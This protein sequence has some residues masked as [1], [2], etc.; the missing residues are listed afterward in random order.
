MTT[1]LSTLLHHH[2]WPQNLFLISQITTNSCTCEVE[3]SVQAS[4]SEVFSK[5]LRKWMLFSFSFLFLQCPGFWRALSL[6]VWLLS[7]RHLCVNLLSPG[8]QCSHAAGILGSSGACHTVWR[9]FQ[10]FVC[11][12]PCPFCHT[13]LLDGSPL[14]CLAFVC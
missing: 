5:L 1:V 11:L 4:Q 2:W 14:S 3:R 8:A 9:E 10:G 13:Q 12:F 6:G 7:R